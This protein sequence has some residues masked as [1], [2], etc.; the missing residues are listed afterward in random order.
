MQQTTH[1][2]GSRLPDINLRHLITAGVASATL[3][4]ACSVIEDSHDSPAINTEVYDDLTGDIGSARY[5][6]IDDPSETAKNKDVYSYDDPKLISFN[7]E[8]DGLR[9]AQDL[10]DGDAKNPR[11]MLSRID[12]S[13]T[14]FPLAQRALDLGK[15][16]K[17]FYETNGLINRNQDSMKALADFTN[18]DFAKEHRD[19]IDEYVLETIYQDMDYY[20]I[21]SISYGMPDI[22][23]ALANLPSDARERLDRAVYANAIFALYLYGQE[24]VDFAQTLIGTYPFSDTKLRDMLLGDI[25]AT[26]EAITTMGDSYFMD[27]RI[28][29][30]SVISD[31]MKVEAGISGYFDD[32]SSKQAIEFM[33]DVQTRDLSDK[34]GAK[35]A[36]YTR[37]IEDR[38]TRLQGV[39]KDGE[40]AFKVEDVE[41]DFGLTDS[42]D[43]KTLSQIHAAPVRIGANLSAKEQREELMQLALVRIKNGAIVFESTSDADDLV[44]DFVRSAALDSKMLI[45]PA[46]ESGQLSMVR[47]TIGNTDTAHFSPASGEV[48]IELSTDRGISYDDLSTTITHEVI[49]ALTNRT[50][51]DGYGVTVSQEKD[52][53]RA[54]DA[55][56]RNL[57][58]QADEELE[59]IVGQLKQLAESS[60]NEKIIKEIIRQVT[61]DSKPFGQNYPWARVNTDGK[62]GAI[63]CINSTI[64]DV[65]DSLLIGSGDY[66]FTYEDIANLVIELSDGYDNEYHAPSAI[67]EA[68][69]NVQ[70]MTSIYGH[71]NE[72]SRVEADYDVSYYGHSQDNANELMAST[73]SFALRDRDLFVKTIRNLDRDDRLPV[74]SLFRNTIAIITDLNPAS[75]GYMSAVEADIMARINA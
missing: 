13:L 9:T 55:L 7:A 2:S 37:K 66:D 18:T 34:I 19:L 42:L 36:R 16:S 50:D 56:K 64:Y 28:S 6:V 51:M 45:L 5:D 63:D 52:V 71:I 57:G 59:A 70:W 24:G 68:L 39:P 48:V 11:R 73:M 32:T 12:E 72:S 21:G 35:I 22:N 74:I 75:L 46:M 31:T 17:A 41:A 10:L 61:N 40:L 53:L 43:A 25:D 14:A 30:L 15:V 49:H 3:L 33:I 23:L 1:E 54:C 58:K 65:I 67:Y 8:L 47:F 4:P 69:S 44:L 20:Q 62:I 38:I 27:D 26:L 60:P 29:G